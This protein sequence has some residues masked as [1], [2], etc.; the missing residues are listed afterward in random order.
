MFGPWNYNNIQAINTQNT[1]ISSSSIFLMPATC[2]EIYKTIHSLNNTNSTGYDEL[3]T[4]ILKQC[5]IAIT[6]VLC[7]IINLSLTEGT[8]PDKLKISIV[9]PIYKKGHKECINNYRPITLIPILAKI[10]EKIMH[11]RLTTFL[12]KSEV[13]KSEQHG[14]QKGKSTT[15]A[16]FKLISKITENVDRKIPTVGV[17]FDMTKA[18]DFVD[19]NI[20]LRKCNNYGIRG[21]AEKWLSSYLSNRQQYVEIRDIDNNNEEVAFKSSLAYN[22]VGVPQGSI[23]GPLLFIIYINDLPEHIHYP[24]SL[25]A[26]DIAVVITKDATLDLNDEINATVSK[27]IDWMNKNN[28]K[29]N[30][31]KTRYIQFYNRHKFINNLNITYNNNTLNECN[32][33][34]FLGLNVDNQC[35]WNLHIDITCSKINRFSYALWRLTKI[36][37]LKTALQ[38]YHGYVASNIRYCI[39]LWGNSSH[40]NRV[41]IAQKQCVRA[42][43][44]IHPLT[45]CK[46]F[47][48]KHNILTVPS[49]YIQE[50]CLFVKKHPQLYKSCGEY[51]QFNTRYPTK[52]ML[53][54]INTR[55]Y[56][57]N[58]YP[59]TIRIFN[60]IPNSI[61][62]LPLTQF[63]RKLYLWLIDKAYYSVQEFLNDKCCT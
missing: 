47:F 39:P 18:F 23:L 45:S 54:S 37:N 57:T 27:V 3:P 33:I 30:L 5:A 31:D 11:S 49:I 40:I 58:C 21:I 51:C 44:N 17:F 43:C 10:F 42:M 36:C 6:P 32:S 34:T 46:P 19:H 16:A 1:N 4:F 22:K 13:I 50:C 56:H 12:N 41:F 9:K 52:L 60:K 62:D 29:A 35:S 38:A 59:M 15:L 24:C 20:L 63:K 55:Y 8:F 53:P 14:F 26:D 48:Q 7:H 2:E 61:R 28:L 25:F